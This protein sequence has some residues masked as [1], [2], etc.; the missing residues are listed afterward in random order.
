KYQVSLKENSS[1][2]WRGASGGNYE[3]TISI[4]GVFGNVPHYPTAWRDIGLELDGDINATI[5]TISVNDGTLVSVGNYL[6]I[7]SETLFVESI[8]T[9][10]LTVKRGELGTTATS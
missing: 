10:D 7:G 9:K 6:Q 3:Q 4:T 1:V 2:R 5:P 8:S